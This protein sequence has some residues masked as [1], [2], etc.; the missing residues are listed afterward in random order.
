[1]E[2][3]RIKEKTS[4]GILRMVSQA[5]LNTGELVKWTTKAYHT[6]DEIPISHHF[7]FPNI[8]KRYCMGKVKEDVREILNTLC[9]Y[10]N[11]EIIAGAVL[12]RSC[13]FKCHNTT[14]IS[15]S[16]F[17]GYLKRVKAP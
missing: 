2:T 14:E 17:M 1:M 10:K 3:V 15:V 13:A 8:G 5:K 11:V 6:L 9:K 4:C 16:D 7:S 12:C